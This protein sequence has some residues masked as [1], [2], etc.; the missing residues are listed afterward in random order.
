[1]RTRD[2]ISDE[3]SVPPALTISDL[4]VA[5]PDLDVVGVS[6]RCLAIVGVSARQAWREGEPNGK[7]LGPET[8]D[9]G[10]SDGGGPGGGGGCA[11]ESPRC[12][13]AGGGPGGGGGVVEAT[14]ILQHGHSYE[15][16]WT[17]ISRVGILG[18]AMRGAR[19]RASTRF[20]MRGAMPAGLRELH[21][22]KERFEHIHL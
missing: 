15:S 3:I 4:E 1:M 10:E 6:A 21:D 2:V 9:G 19:G 16:V 8:E 11:K 18:F 20:D 5:V 17:P 12:T 22:E 7:G 14:I 13:A